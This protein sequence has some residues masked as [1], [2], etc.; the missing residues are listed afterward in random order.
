VG[1]RGKENNNGEGQVG[2]RKKATRNRLDAGGAKKRV[3][4]CGY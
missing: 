3:E 4:I 2:K 1:G